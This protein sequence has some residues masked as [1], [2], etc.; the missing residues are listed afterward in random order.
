M[1]IFMWTLGT[2]E[3]TLKWV[4]TGSKAT[5]II[6]PSP[7]YGLLQGPE[8]AHKVYLPEYSWD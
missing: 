4:I 1:Q 8:W 2:V 6:L 3:S 7:H 5:I